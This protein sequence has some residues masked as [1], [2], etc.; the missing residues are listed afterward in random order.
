MLPWFASSS[1]W[2]FS[3][4]SISRLSESR[5]TAI[6]SSS[7]SFLDLFPFSFFFFV[8][9]DVPSSLLSFFLPPPTIF[10]RTLV[11]ETDRERDRSRSSPLPRPRPRPRPLELED[12]SSSSSP[13]WLMLFD[14]GGFLL[15]YWL[16]GTKLLRPS[17]SELPSWLALGMGLLRPGSGAAAEDLFPP[18]PNKPLF[19]FFGDFGDKNWL[20]VGTWNTQLALTFEKSCVSH[21]NERER[22]SS[23]GKLQSKTFQSGY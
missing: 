15:V 3:D 10:R 1:S 16:P 21:K 23:D 13:P 22:L 11:T 20:M 9:F 4:S 5:D 19:F 18:N 6:P 8:F 14:E 7:S 12:A 2:S 17:S